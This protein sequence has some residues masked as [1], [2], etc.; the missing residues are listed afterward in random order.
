MISSTA[1]FACSDIPATLTHYKEVLGFENIWSYGDPPSFGGA[2]TGGANIM[3]CLDA[4]LAKGVR[5]H[6][7]WIN[8]EDADQAFQTH[9]DNGANIVSPIE[10][11]PWDVREY[12]VED[13]NGYRLRFAGPL[14]H[15]DKSEP[16][17]EGV[18]VAR[19]KPTLEEYAK[20]ASSAFGHKEPF[21]ELLDRTWG[22]VVALS[23]AG[24]AV[25]VVRI[26]LDAP[27]WFSI[28]DVAVLPEWQGKHI[29]SKIMQESLD[30]IREA[31]PGA[32]VYLFTY[33]HGFYEKL[34][35][36]RESV[37]MR[38]L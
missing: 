28:W 29:G 2:S 1:I 21:P 6:Q 18:I 13:L 19:R 27:G 11:K 36:G 34:G 22:G 32:I 38:R 15:T 35:F 12:V 33:K 10:N 8:V 37:S 24:E 23:P 3:F 7:H 5:G 4:E 20:V 9:R 14:P 26:M 30:C 31:K 17:P 16:L 25:G